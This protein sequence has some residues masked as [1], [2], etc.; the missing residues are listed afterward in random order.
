MPKCSAAPNPYPSL[1]VPAHAFFSS[2]ST[3]FFL[4]P[5]GSDVLAH[6]PLTLPSL[7]IKNFSKFHFTRFNPINP[8]FSPFIHSHTGSA[9]AP[10][11]SVFPRI[12][13]VVLNRPVQKFWICSSEPGSW[14]PNWLQGKARRLKSAGYLA[15]RSSQRVCRGPYCLVKPHSEAVLTTRTTLPRCCER[16][17]PATC[18]N[19][20]LEKGEALVTI[21]G[22]KVEKGLGSVCHFA[23]VR[24]RSRCCGG[25]RSLVLSVTP[26]VQK[27]SCL[28]DATLSR[29]SLELDTGLEE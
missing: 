16:S 23:L 6:L 24:T 5:A 2:S 3:I 20:R 27:R 12:S 8:A 14:P 15:E 11:T 10:F 29:L 21:S 17:Y 26:D 4:N 9:S 19:G 22:R 18:Q 7:P 13:N 1:I 25:K 28:C